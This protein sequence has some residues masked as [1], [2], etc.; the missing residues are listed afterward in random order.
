M[1]RI[2]LGQAGRAKRNDQW[3]AVLRGAGR[4]C[5][6]A[7]AVQASVD[8][9]GVLV[10]GR[11]KQ[12][13]ALRGRVLRVLSPSGR[14]FRVAGLVGIYNLTFAGART[15]LRAAAPRAPRASTAAAGAVA[16]LVLAMDDHPN[17]RVTLALYALVRACYFMALTLARWHGMQAWGGDGGAIAWA[18]EHGNVATFVISNFEIM[19]SWFYHPERLP[20]AYEF[21]ISKMAELDPRIRLVLRAKYAGSVK[22]GERTDFLAEYCREHKLDP[23]CADFVTRKPIPRVVVHPTDTSSTM[24]VLRRFGR[25]FMNSAAMYLPVY[26]VPSLLMRPAEVTHA[27]AAWLTRLALKTGQSSMFLASYISNI[28]AWIYG[29]RLALR[30]DTTLG[31]FLGCLTCGFSILLERKGRRSELALYVFP[32]ALHS[33]WTL[34]CQRGL[35]T[36][37]RNGE[38]Y[39]FSCAMAIIMFHLEHEHASTKSLQWLLSFVISKST[40]RRSGE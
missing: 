19:F 2:D 5:G 9:V 29:T 18:M 3:E 13:P 7:F 23:R 28:F 30:D 38:V 16:G 20:P 4:C 24:N 25:G 21:W 37:M 15:A 32:R 22:Y 6:V 33:W 10:A 35:V 12:W 8:T 39:V 27:P 14:A 26:A 11:R 31:P 40:Y 36:P 34:C 1:S 17:R